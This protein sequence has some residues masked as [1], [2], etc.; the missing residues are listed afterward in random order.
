MNA[1][2]MLDRLH[3]ILIELQPRRVGAPVLQKSPLRQAIRYTLG[4][5]EAL[6]RYL[7][8]GRYEIDNNL[9]ENAVR[10]TCIGKK[11]WLFIGHPDAG[12]R[13]AV[14]Y[15][16]LVTARRYGLDPAAWLT[17]VLRWIPS[18]TPANLAE[19]LPSNWKPQADGDP[20]ARQS[21]EESVRW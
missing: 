9:V 1:L 21:V 12:W 14:I 8:D 17:D 20:T 6:V 10:P 13:S 5:W 2:A 11:N 15:S 19:L 16:I 4:Q 3:R 7:E 18:C